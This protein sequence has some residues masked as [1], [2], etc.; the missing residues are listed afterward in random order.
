MSVRESVLTFVA[1]VHPMAGAALL[2]IALAHRQIFW[3]PFWMRGCIPHYLSLSA[4]G[5]FELPLAGHD[6][7]EPRQVESLDSQTVGRVV[8]LSPGAVAADRRKIR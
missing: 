1:R 4:R 8:R 2:R 5:R 6:G 7:I 3:R